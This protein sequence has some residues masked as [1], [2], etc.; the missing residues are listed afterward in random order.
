MPT[1]CKK[2]HENLAKSRQIAQLIFPQEFFCLWEELHY[3]YKKLGINEAKKEALQDAIYSFIVQEDCDE[4][5]FKK[6]LFF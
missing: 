1:I 3:I 5:V 2:H 4:V 6:T